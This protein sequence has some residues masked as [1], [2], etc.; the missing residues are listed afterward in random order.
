M[1]DFTYYTPTR[2]VFGKNTEHQTGALVK[3]CKCSKVL[4]RYGG[5]SALR[6][7]LV[8]RIT[9]SLPR[10]RRDWRIRALLARFRPG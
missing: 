4:I 8:D 5:Q 2:V 3:A 6:S 9:A 1:H 10:G 7:G